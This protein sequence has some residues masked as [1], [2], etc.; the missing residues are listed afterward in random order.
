MA[1]HVRAG[2]VDCLYGYASADYNSSCSWLGSVQWL[3]DTSP[4]IKNQLMQE[5]RLDLLHFQS[6]CVR[7][8]F[9][10]CGLIFC[11]NC[12]NQKEIALSVLAQKQKEP[13]RTKRER[14]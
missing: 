14:I 13:Q 10:N 2:R 8:A 6:V 4:S 5:A 1:I 12:Y 11:W 7:K 9:R 3:G